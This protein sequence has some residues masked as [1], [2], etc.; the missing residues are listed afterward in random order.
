M[1]FDTHAHYWD[2]RFA[3]EMPEGADACI[4]SLFDTGRVCGIVNVG[5][6]PET[7][8]LSIEQ[9]RRFPGMY[10]TA[11]IH[12]SDCAD[13]DDVHKAL[14]EIASLFLDPQNKLVALGEIGLDYHY[15][16]FDKERQL[17][18][19][20]KQLDLA[21]K[22]DMPV[23]LHDR[24]SHEDILTAIKEHPHVHGVF[25]SFSGSAEMAKEV[26]K[27]GYYVSFSGTLT[28]KN[29][30]KPREALLAVPRE[31]VLIETDAPYLAPHPHRGKCNHSG[32]LSF[33]I[34][35]LAD[36]WQVTPSEATAITTANAKRFF[37]I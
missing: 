29:A 19:L 18:F 32:Y 27:S 28:F 10:A 30:R 36:L 24:E 16:P 2:D 34:D 25:H 22:L 35:M 13:I 23:I 7:S 12:P 5:T 31:R 17:L 1:I 14:D 15:L 9:A 20:H 33:V 37:R 26:V 4:G 3:S 8:R 6:S 11:G 21:E